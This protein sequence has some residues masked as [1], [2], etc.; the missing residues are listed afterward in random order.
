MAA[1]G[2][3]G[4]RVAARAEAVVTGMSAIG[5]TDGRR[6]IDVTRAT[7]R[8]VRWENCVAVG[9][10]TLIG[11]HL[12]G[13]ALTAEGYAAAGTVMV[14]HA[15]GTTLNDRC[16]V[17]V[18]RLA[19]PHRPLPSGR[20]SLR[21]ADRLAAVLA[22]AGL[23]CAALLGRAAF[24]VAVVVVLASVAYAVRL[25][26]SVLVGNLTVAALS[27]ATGPFGAA[28]VTDGDV[29]T[30]A[31]VGG[32][33]IFAY[34]V[35]YEV[36]KCLQDIDSDAAAGIRTIAT[37]MGTRVARASALFAL[38]VFACVALW[39]AMTGSASAGYRIA[40]ILP[41]VCVVGAALSAHLVL[42]L[43]RAWDRAVGWLKVGWFVSLPALFLL[44]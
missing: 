31:L 5:V 42:P 35:A 14:L 38:T 15:A 6:V 4:G 11:A 7:L 33:L 13:G 19:R 10:T 20:L 34:M 27:G 29:P 23:A 12:A 8:L 18:D 3:E 40:V 22:V 39:P 41:I 1:D 32:V 30:S 21:F 36:L 28:A 2:A 17:A 9:L 43:P 24:A 25:K 37:V 44:A 26:N 16:D